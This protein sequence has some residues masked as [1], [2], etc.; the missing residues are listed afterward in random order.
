MKYVNVTYYQSRQQNK[1]EILTVFSKNLAVAS[2]F[3]FS[4]GGGSEEKEGLRD[5]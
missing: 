4:Q 3:P 2:S 1:K 5:V